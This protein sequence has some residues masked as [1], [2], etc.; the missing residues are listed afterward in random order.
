MYHLNMTFMEKF[1]GELQKQGSNLKLWLLI[2]VMKSVI[3]YKKYHID[4]VP[5]SNSDFYQSGTLTLRIITV[6]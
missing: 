5:G 4:M 1:I 2:V 6:L 3:M